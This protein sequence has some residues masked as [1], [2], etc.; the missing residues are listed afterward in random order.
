MKYDLLE[1]D[2]SLTLLRLL[3]LLLA[4][5]LL[6]LSLSRPASLLCLWSFP[7][8]REAL[9]VG[10]RANEVA[11]LVL[12]LVAAV[13]VFALLAGGGCASFKLCTDN[14]V[15]DTVEPPD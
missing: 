8:L 6:L 5:L 4:A 3:L 15:A 14:D 9:A 13:A 7:S 12:L 1:E 11:L 2:S 10:T